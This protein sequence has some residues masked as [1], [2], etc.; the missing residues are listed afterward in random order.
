MFELSA[1]KALRI[2][3]R[4]L[5]IRFS[6][7]AIIVNEITKPEPPDIRIAFA[8]T[9]T[10]VLQLALE[11]SSTDGD[12]TGPLPMGLQITNIGGATAKNCILRLIHPTTF[13]ISSNTMQLEQK[14]IYGNTL[15][16]MTTINLPDIHPGQTVY[17]DKDLEAAANNQKDVLVDIAPYNPSSAPDFNEN[18]PVFLPITDKRVD[19][20]ST[21][22]FEVHRK[23]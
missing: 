7:G 10:S 12:G 23:P 6:S 22:T 2:S 11:E 21:L 19:E 18:P 8:L 4:I 15:T 17:F 13:K 3:S 16:T 1:D 14:E 5:W 9:K 20:G